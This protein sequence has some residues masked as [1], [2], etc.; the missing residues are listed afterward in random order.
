MKRIFIASAFILFAAMVQAQNVGIGVPVP[1]QKL[2]VNGAIKIGT[3]TTNQ[4]GAIRFNAGKFEGGDGT[5]WKSFEALPTNS[6]V[7]SKTNPNTALQN[8]GYSYFGDFNYNYYDSITL[9]SEAEKWYTTSLSNPPQV[10]DNAFIFWSG[11]EFLIWNKSNGVVNV[12][13]KYN[14][15]ADQW[16]SFFGLNTPFLADLA[17]WTG[18]ELIAWGLGSGNDAPAKF[19]PLTNVWTLISDVNAPAYDLNMTAIWTGTDMIVFGGAGPGGKYNLSTNT[20]T[21]LPTVNAP[22]SRTTHKAVWTGTEMIVW[23]GMATGTGTLLNTGAKYNPSTNTWAPI[24]STTLSGRVAFTAVWTGT[25]MVIMGGGPAIFGG[26][27]SVFKDGA[28]Y[29]PSTNSWTPM[30]I[31]ATV[32][33]IKGA[34]AVWTGT[35]IIYWGGFDLDASNLPPYVPEHNYGARYNPATNNWNNFTQNNNIPNRRV[36]HSAAWNGNIMMVFGGRSV[37]DGN[38]GYTLNSGGRYFLTGGSSITEVI[39]K[40]KIYLYIRN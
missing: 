36:Y 11:T 39:L 37:D 20:W 40:D 8:L 2:D 33:N 38:V 13:H 9:V 29:N 28:E 7:F 18:N 22:S 30:V 27:G 5:N 1:L 15:V 24:A 32:Y 25:E 6:L 21:A 12:L 34:S 14:A 10:S 31:P 16:T 23:G 17:V 4:P 3:T 19:N 35:E 26:G